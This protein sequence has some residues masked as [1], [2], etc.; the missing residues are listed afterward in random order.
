MAYVSACQLRAKDVLLIELELSIGAVG[1][2]V[3]VVTVI[4]EDEVEP[5]AFV[6]MTIT[7]LYV[8]TGMSPLKVAVLVPIEFGDI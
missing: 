5:P 7:V 1:G 2:G 8:V 3:S 4:G 6:A